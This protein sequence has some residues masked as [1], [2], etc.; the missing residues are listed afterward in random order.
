MIEQMIPL[1]CATQMFLSAVSESG[2]KRRRHEII[3][4]FMALCAK[5][6]GLNGRAMP[7]LF[8]HKQRNKRSTSPLISEQ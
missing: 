8:D 4:C 5:D 2:N 6:S 7:P 3:I 1:H